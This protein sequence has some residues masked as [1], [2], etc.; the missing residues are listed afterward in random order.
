[1]GLT[2]RF[3]DPVEDEMTREFLANGYVV[4]DV[5]NRP[6]LDA[7]RH[8]IVRLACG[9]LKCDMPADDGEFLNRVHERVAVSEINALRLHVFNGLN[10]HAWCRPSYLALARSAIDRLVGNELAMQNKVNLSIQMPND[11][12]ST[13]AVHADVWSAETPYEVVQWTPLVDVHDTK[14]MYI[15]RPEV[16]RTVRDRMSTLKD[17]GRDF[18]L[19]EAYRDEF[20]WVPVKYGQTLVFSPILLHGNVRNDTTE[21]RWSL[22]CRLTGLFTPY[23]SDEKCLG[24]FYT[25]VTPKVASRIGMNYRAPEAIDG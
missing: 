12:T 10:A 19:F 22:N 20:H 5:D 15:L 6:A 4:R 17:G 21:S 8:E 3:T 18:D 14:A 11:E 23:A 16:N 24:R 7:I 25:P 2:D 9:H 1:M 13:L